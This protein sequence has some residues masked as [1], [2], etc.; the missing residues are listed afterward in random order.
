MNE[1]GAFYSQLAVF[2]TQLVG[3]LALSLGAVYLMQ[4]VRNKPWYDKDGAAN[5]LAKVRK[6]V[7]TTEERPGDNM[8]V[9]IQ[10]AAV[11]VF[12]SVVV[13]AKF[14]MHAG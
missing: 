8:A 12:L 2:A 1:I 7:G 13:L 11:T 10:Y 9:A 5:E 14:L 6:R 4:A 3:L